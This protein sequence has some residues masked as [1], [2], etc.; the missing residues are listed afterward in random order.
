VSYVVNN[1]PRPVAKHTRARV[2]AAIEELDY[3]PNGLAR[4]LRSQK[5][6]LLGLILPDLSNPFFATLAHAV[7]TA[8]RA[9]EFLVILASTN[10]DMKQ[11]TKCLVD[12]LEQRVDRILLISSSETSSYPVPDSLLRSLNNSSVK[13]V[14]LDRQPPG[15]DATSLIID[16]E[17]GGYLATQHLLGHGHKDVGCLA[18]PASLSSAEA[19]TRGWSR[20]LTEAGLTPSDSLLVRRPFSWEGGYDGTAALLSSA[21]PP[22]ALFVQSDQQAMGGLRAAKDNRVRVPQDLALVSFDGIPGGPYSDPPLSTI[23]QP[24]AAAGRRAVELLLSDVS[25]PVGEQRHEMLPVNLTLRDSC[26]CTGAAKSIAF[27][28]AG[29][30]RRHHEPAR[31]ASK[32]RTE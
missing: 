3:R 12:M 10:D 28:S 1:G 14:L 9:E 26:G 6:K 30:D 31:R 23:D 19:R 7:E 16:N 27:A 18:G 22:T 17:A 4:A 29:G 32:G 20:A 25:A 24:T 13:I 8:A 21:Q 2:L 11:E 15:L 5:S